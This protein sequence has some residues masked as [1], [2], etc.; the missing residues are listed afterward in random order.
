MR[1]WFTGVVEGFVQS[2]GRALYAAHGLFGVP[3]PTSPSVNPGGAGGSGGSWS[4]P[5]AG[6]EQASGTVLQDRRAGFGVLDRA[7]DEWARTTAADT[8]RSRRAVA[9]LISS[10]DG[11]ARA[12]A[13][14]ANTV[15]AGW[16]CS[17]RC[18]IIWGV[19]IR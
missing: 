7:L 18:W 16:R 2:V 13:P 6:R 11:S 1:C 5:A 15:P 10:A 4:G 9:A 14:Y 3:V 8:E 17:V 12:L 19:V